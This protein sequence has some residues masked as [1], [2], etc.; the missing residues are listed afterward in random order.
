MTPLTPARPVAAVVKR[1]VSLLRTQWFDS[2][3]CHSD[4]FGKLFAGPDQSEIADFA[5]EDDTGQSGAD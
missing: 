4:R 2:L 5:D 3:G 1:Q